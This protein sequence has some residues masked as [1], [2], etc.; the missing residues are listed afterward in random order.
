MSKLVPSVYFPV[1]IPVYNH[2]G[3]PGV[4]LVVKDREIK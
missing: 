2:Y 4:R 3:P 1:S